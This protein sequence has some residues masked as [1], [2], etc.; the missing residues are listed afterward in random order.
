[1]PTNRR[2]RST[3]ALGHRYF[4]QLATGQEKLNIDSR[5]LGPCGPPPLS[6]EYTRASFQVQYAYE[7]SPYTS[8]TIT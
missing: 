3:Q 6:L 1:M 2:F 8:S 5:F 4:F 7:V